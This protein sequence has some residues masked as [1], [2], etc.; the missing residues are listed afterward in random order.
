V[1]E[2][3][4]RIVALFFFISIYSSKQSCTRLMLNVVKCTE[5]VAIYFS[6]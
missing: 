3:Y 6:H 2:I 4:L 5:T 1:I